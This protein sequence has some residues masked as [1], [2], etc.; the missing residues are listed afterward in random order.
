MAENSLLKKVDP[1][2]DGAGKVSGS[3]MMAAMERDTTARGIR[4]SRPM[5]RP[6]AQQRGALD[7]GTLVAGLVTGSVKFL[8]ESWARSVASLTQWPVSPR[9][10]TPS[11]PADLA[12]PARS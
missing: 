10:L 11:G 4:A 9:L 8:P 5:P 1:S 7:T 3:A 2:N 6:A 12:V